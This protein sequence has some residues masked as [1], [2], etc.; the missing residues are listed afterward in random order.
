MQAA[1]SGQFQ[2]N[3]WLNQQM[4]QRTKQ[5]FLH[6]SYI[7]ETYIYTHTHMYIYICMRHVKLNVHHSTF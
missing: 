4:G 7:Y 3:K 6:V 5:T 1:P 2:K